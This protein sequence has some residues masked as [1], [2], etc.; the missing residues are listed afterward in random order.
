MY[1]TI[2][3]VINDMKI[4]YPPTSS[5]KLSVSRPVSV[6]SK[7]DNWAAERN[8][9]PQTVMERALSHTVGS[10]VEQA[11]ARSGL[12]DQRRAL[13]TQWATCATETSAE[14]ADADP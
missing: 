5:A 10:A 8:N 12:L 6:S 7:V 4:S 14:I 3:F 2:T 9:A 1:E 13:M 11:C